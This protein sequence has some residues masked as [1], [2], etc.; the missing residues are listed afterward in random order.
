V[1]QR[2]WSVRRERQSFRTQH[3]PHRRGTALDRAVDTDPSS[4]RGSNRDELY[5]E[6]RDLNIRGRSMMTKQELR[7]AVDRKTGR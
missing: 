5:E 7:G 1:P 2:V 6:A 4:H 3:G